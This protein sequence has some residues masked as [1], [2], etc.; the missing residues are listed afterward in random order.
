MKKTLILSIF[1]AM[2]VFTSSANAMYPLEIRN[3]TMMLGG[4]FSFTN[5]KY[6][7]D[8]GDTVSGNILTISPSFGYFLSSNFGVTAGVNYMR[9]DGD[10]YT[11]YSDLFG[12]KLGALFMQR[13]LAVYLYVGV[14]AGYVRLMPAEGD[15]DNGLILGGN[16][17]L[18]LPLNPHVA[19][20]TSIKLIYSLNDSNSDQLSISFGYFGI[21][22]FF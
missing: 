19:L 12:L 3:G 7:P 16:V 8:E 13:L 15:A 20:T 6:I 10:A 22:A 14:D 18:M 11:G 5:D 9:H 17:G 4:E 1:L 21:S 2:A